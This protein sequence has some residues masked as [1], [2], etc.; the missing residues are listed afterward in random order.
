MSVVT[1]DDLL[2]DPSA[3]QSIPAP[4]FVRVMRAFVA[5]PAAAYPD[6][7]S[8]PVPLVFVAEQRSRKVGPGSPEDSQ[9][10]NVEQDE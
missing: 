1:L 2:P 10:Q 3:L 6:P 5:P 7:R 4:I 8:T 9:K